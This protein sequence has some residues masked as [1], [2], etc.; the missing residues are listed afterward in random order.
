M[1][2]FYCN[3]RIIYYE[4]QDII[5]FN[6]QDYYFCKMETKFEFR[7]ILAADN[8]IIAQIIRESLI[9]YGGDKPGT[10]F[11]DYDTDHMFEAY[12][13]KGELYLIAESG[14]NVAGGCGIKQLKGG[15]PEFC[16]LQKLYLSA[17]KRG[18]GIGRKLVE[19]CLEFA[20]QSGY[21]QCYLETFPN[22]T[23]AI[24]LYLKFGFERLKAPLGSTGHCGCDIWMVKHLQ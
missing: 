11:Y 14:G 8:Q 3:F 2:R 9:Q 6:K 12:Q 7:N 4:V 19:K 13:G 16:E 21:K 15:D 5:F 20:S 1:N 17:D 18:F 23:E 22:M 10:A 24:N